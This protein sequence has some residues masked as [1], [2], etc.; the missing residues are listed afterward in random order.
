[1]NKITLSIHLAVFM[2]GLIACSNQTDQV[3][4]NDQKV[5]N[6]NEQDKKIHVNKDV[7]E[8]V[9]GQLSS[10]Q[11]ERIDGTWEFGKVS[12]IILN[13]D[14]MSLINDKTY[15]GKEVYL[16]D[17]P[18]KNK[19]IPNNMIVYADLKTFDYIGSGLVE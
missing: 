5:V 13:E 7:R 8:V 9:W 15:D 14:M 4:N 2:L 18:T 11:K 1:M 12:K 16:I 10:E 17:F 6:S 19:F 3:E